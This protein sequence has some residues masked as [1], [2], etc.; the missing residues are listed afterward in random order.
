M[1]SSMA[2][3][4]VVGRSSV[5][6]GNLVL[7]ILIVSCFRATKISECW[8]KGAFVGAESLVSVLWSSGSSRPKSRVRRLMGRMLLRLYE[9]PA[10][11][12]GFLEGG[13]APDPPLPFLPLMEEK[14]AKEDQALNRGRGSLS[15][16]CRV[17]KGACFCPAGRR[18]Q[19]RVPVFVQRIVAAK[20][21]GANLFS[22]S[23]RPKSRVRI[24]SAVR[25]GENRG[26][27]FVQRL[28]AAKI[29]GAN[30]FSGSSRSKSRVR[31]CSAGCPS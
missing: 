27:E 21:A 16:T 13:F 26:C 29:A 19:N 1:P 8:R 2:S 10:S 6:T 3:G 17:Q 20:I 11:W 9:V 30:S 12:P 14:E 28:V 24:R 22:G 4:A 25:R 18:D 7:M 23:S 5:T 31:I 15:G